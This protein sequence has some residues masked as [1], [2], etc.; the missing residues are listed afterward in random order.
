MD[1]EHELLQGH[2]RNWVAV[3][4]R[5]TKRGRIVEM[6]LRANDV[7][8]EQIPIVA[9]ELKRLIGEKRALI[10]EVG[11]NA[12]HTTR[13]F[14]QSMPDAEIFCFEPDPRAIAQFKGMIAEKN[15]TL[16]QSAVGNQNGVV[17]FHQSDGEGNMK[18]WNQ[19]GSIRRPKMHHI[20][21][22]SVKFDKQIDVPIVRLDDWA[23]ERKLGPVDLLWADV[24]GAE[25]D[26][27]AGA[28]KTLRSTR[29]FY[30]EYG[31][32]EWYEGQITLVDICELVAELGFVLYRKWR[33]DALFVNK[34]LR[35]LKG[36]DFK[37]S[38]NKP[39]PCGSTLRY[40]HCH[41]SYKS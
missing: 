19:S 28:S 26:L 36:L 11:A 17:S 40:K 30:T 24:Q 22:P 39:C 5:D 2:Y 15:V 14:L 7:E 38:R 8:L 21:F 33:I 41:G 35:D 37:I 1:P 6:H 10:L 31:A 12:G 4:T 32:L 16:I 23:A 9:D 29:F 13:D 27:I 20:T 18:D 3:P 25:S 34:D